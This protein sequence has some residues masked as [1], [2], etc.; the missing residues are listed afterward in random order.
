MGTPVAIQPGMLRITKQK[1][2]DTVLLRL[3]GT[4]RSSPPTSAG[5][6]TGTESFVDRGIAPG[7]GGRSRKC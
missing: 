7:A 4:D 1:Q 6:V 5:Q 3:E 2:G